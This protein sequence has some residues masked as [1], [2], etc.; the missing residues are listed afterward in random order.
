MV[1]MVEADEHRYHFGYQLSETENV[2]FAATTS[3]KYLSAEVAD[4]FTGVFVGMYATANGM[5]VPAW[6][7]YD[8]FDY[9]P[10]T[11]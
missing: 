7:D 6:V 9:E 5:D 11:R 3:A 8:W 1:F 2:E 10:M 4:S